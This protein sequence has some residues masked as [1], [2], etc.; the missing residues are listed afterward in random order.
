MSELM[1]Y[2][3]KQIQTTTTI[4]ML[5][6]CICAYNNNVF[7]IKS[8]NYALNLFDG[9]ARFFA[10]HN[11]WS[12][13]KRKK[14][15]K[16]AA[17]AKDLGKASKSIEA[18]SRACGGDL[19]NI[20]LQSA[21]NSAKALQLPKDRINDAIER[22]TSSKDSGGP[23]YENLR[24]DGMIQTPTS[25]KVAVIITAL[26]DNRN[27]TAARVRALLRKSG[28]DILPT[29]ANDWLFDHVGIITIPKLS[30]WTENSGHEDNLIERALEG[31][32]IDVIPNDD[33]DE[34]MVKCPPTDLQ[35]VLHEIQ[36][37]DEFSPSTFHTS[38]LAK[39][40]GNLLTLDEESSSFFDEVLSKFDDDDDVENV[41]HNALD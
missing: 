8:D 22:G 7:G 5:R 30:D 14:G 3:F 27:R 33:N 18:A 28:G 37:G 26:T 31:G 2:V 19:T 1:S 34:L 32:A 25:G 4:N 11:K 20:N 13:I 29:G 17:R 23:D 6:R 39:D 16:D 10:G 21:I 36:K 24:Y 9:Q 12:K 35:S 15:L 38:Y 41:Y 40:E